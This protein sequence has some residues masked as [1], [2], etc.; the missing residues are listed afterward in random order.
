MGHAINHL[1]AFGVL[2]AAVAPAMGSAPA[3]AD[4]ISNIAT[5]QWNVGAT[6]VVN[7]S[8]QVDLQVDR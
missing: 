2:L 5:I 7:Q 3:R 8:N 6:T 4:T 1:K